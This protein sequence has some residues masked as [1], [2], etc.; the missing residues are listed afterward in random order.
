MLP[1]TPRIPSFI[2]YVQSLSS[3]FLIL[4]P[5]QCLSLSIPIS[6]SFFLF[7]SLD[8]SP[9][10]SHHMHPRPSLILRPSFLEFL[11]F[12]CCFLLSLSLSLFI[13]FYSMP[14]CTS[15]F[16]C[17]QFSLKI[18]SWSFDPFHL[19]LSFTISRS[20]LLSLVSFLSSDLSFSLNPV[21][22]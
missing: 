16:P 2:L 5:A 11:L 14:F 21:C 20:P 1:S 6:F 13:S 18:P 10:I 12:P 7:L 19:S 15:A 3:L 22:S 17:Y 9:L 8:F 4:L